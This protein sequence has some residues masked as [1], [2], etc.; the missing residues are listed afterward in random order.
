MD[1]YLYE[2][3]LKAYG[4]NQI[5]LKDRIF[6]K[7]MARSQLDRVFELHSFQETHVPVNLK[8]EEHTMI[9]TFRLRTDAFNDWESKSS[10]RQFET[11][12]E[13]FSYFCDQLDHLR[14]KTNLYYEQYKNSEDQSLEHLFFSVLK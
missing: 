6:R 3:I 1:R 12:E 4:R 13:V 8:Y 7:L 5:R 9:F 10:L 2:V 11:F 14:R